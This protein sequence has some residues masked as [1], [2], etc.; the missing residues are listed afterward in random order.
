[1]FLNSKENSC[2]GKQNRFI[3]LTTSKSPYYGQI[4]QIYLPLNRE[5]PILRS[6][7]TNLS[8]FKSRKAHTTVI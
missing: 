7:K 6:D 8:P 2:F 4:K 1:M 3:S 5:K